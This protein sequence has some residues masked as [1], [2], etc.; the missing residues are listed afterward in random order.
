[1]NK[2][3][4][5]EF[6]ETGS[7]LGEVPCGFWMHF[8]EEEQ[9]GP[10]AIDAHIRYYSRTGVPLIKVM[11]EHYFQLG[12]TIE[13]TEDWR[14]IQAEEKNEI[15]YQEYLSEIR[16]IRERMGNE[17]LIL[18]TI[19]GVLVSACHAT[20]GLG[21]FTNPDNTVTRHLKEDPES[22]IEGLK[23]IAMILKK[24]CLECM[25]AG[26]DGIYYALLGAEEQRF[27]QEFFETYIK[28]VEIELLQDVKKEG[29]V[30]L[31]ICKDN[32][33]LPMLKEYPAHVVNWAVNNGA[34]GLR[35]GADIF[36]DKIIM[37]GFENRFGTLLTGS[38]QEI[39]QEMKEMAEEAGRERL[40]VGADCTLSN[41]VSMEQIKKA[42][43]ACKEI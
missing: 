33:R 20:D 12:K 19:H 26:A 43:E 17:S 9:C 2:K 16:G 22:V 30:F 10:K 41:T 3:E 27:T 35:E 24:L 28:P 29:I 6:L 8:N 39:M 31:H 21:I 38:K 23:Q 13:K 37:G 32:P 7:N 15:N 5:M 18:A 40:I 34:Y 36:S 14:D 11:N 25:E 1:M 4:L 42:V